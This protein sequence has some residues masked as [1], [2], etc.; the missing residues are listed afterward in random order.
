MRFHRKSMDVGEY[1]LTRYRSSFSL[2]PYRAYCV[3]WLA[4]EKMVSL[5]LVIS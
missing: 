4:P 3:A 2:E 1:C 5:D